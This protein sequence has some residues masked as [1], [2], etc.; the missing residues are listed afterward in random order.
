MDWKAIK[1]GLKASAIASACCTTPLV[2]GVVAVTTSLISLTTAISV[3]EYKG[4]FIA[5]G[6]LFYVMAVYLNLKTRCG[7]VC[8]VKSIKDTWVFIATSFLAYAVV[9]LLLVYAILPVLAGILFA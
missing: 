6:S 3:A 4:F 1:L 5:L 8:S 2:L 9:T 7:G